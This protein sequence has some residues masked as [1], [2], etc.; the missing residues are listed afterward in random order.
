MG[1]EAN[2]VLSCSVTVPDQ[3][4]EIKM[5][6]ASM[7]MTFLFTSVMSLW[8][9]EDARAAAV[10]GRPGDTSVAELR[11]MNK[12]VVKEN[13]ADGLLIVVKDKEYLVCGGKKYPFLVKITLAENSKS[14]KADRHSDVGA[15]AAGVGRGKTITHTQDLGNTGI[16]G[17]IPDQI[18]EI[19]APG[20]GAMDLKDVVAALALSRQEWPRN[21]NIFRVNSM[22]SVD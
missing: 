12:V 6:Q 14:V 4:W 17:I 18:S 9:R 20:G 13:T 2:E 15:V 21:S 8:T 7:H 1:W 19:E 5:Y 10:V 3:L 11:T 16:S 22:M